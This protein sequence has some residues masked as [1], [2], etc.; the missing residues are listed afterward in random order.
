M[1]P[2]EPINGTDGNRERFGNRRQD[3][4]AILFRQRFTDATRHNPSRM[5]SFPSQSL[6]NLLSKL[7]QQN[8]IPSERRILFQHS[9]YIALRRVGIHTQQQVGRRQVKEAQRMRLHYLRHA[10]Q[11]TQFVGRR[12]NSHGHQ[13]IARLGRCDEMAYRADAAD[14]R[15]QRRHLRK[16]TAFAKLLEAAE[17]RNVKT[18]VFDT[19]FLVEMQRDLGMPFDPRYWVDNDRSALFHSNS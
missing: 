10:E 4:I 7:T 13:S 11:P 16:R 1:N 19:A 17:L 15:H 8:A 12:R 9:E 14:A 6:D 3:R 18:C 2:L 5:N